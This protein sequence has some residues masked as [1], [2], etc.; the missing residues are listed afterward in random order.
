MTLWHS[1]DI[2]S[3]TGGINQLP[4]MV[5]GVAID[6]RVVKH[7]DLFVALRGPHHD[8]HDYIPDVMAKGANGLLCE[9]KRGHDFSAV[10]VPNTMEGLWDM[11]REAVNRHQG[12]RIAITGSVGKTGTKNM[13]SK[14]CSALNKTYA[15]EGNLNNHIGVP[16]TL[17]RMAPNI[18]YGIIEMGMNAPDEISPLSKLTRPHVAIIT[19]VYPVHLENFQNIDGIAQAKAEIF[20]GLNEQGIGILPYDSPYYG[21]LKERVKN[22]ISFGQDMKADVALKASQNGHIVCHSPIGELKFYLPLKGMHW[23][24]NAMTVVATLIAFDRQKKNIEQALNSLSGLSPTVGRGNERIMT[25]ANGETFTLVDET[26]NASPPAMNA[27]LDQLRQTP[28]KRRIAVLGGMAELGDNSKQ[29]H[30]NIAIDGIDGVY[31]V[32][33]EIKCLA[34]HENVVGWVESV[35]DLPMIEAKA[36]DVVLVKGSRSMALDRWVKGMEEKYAL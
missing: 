29:L 1:Q 36:G 19:N 20:D 24:I 16:L 30:Q 6:S 27:A 34:T 17:A 11:A 4:F 13:V 31:L 32:G 3:A 23:A 10:E 12:K 9:E 26:Y 33:D 8:G 22:K 28:A 18:D 15:T 5:S 7:G 35:D 14:A 25:L 21:M 2:A